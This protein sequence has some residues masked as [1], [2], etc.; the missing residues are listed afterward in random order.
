MV[1]LP[2][3]V[4]V[5]AVVVRVLWSGYSD[6]DTARQARDV[7]LEETAI[8]YYARA[9]RWYLPVVGPGHEAMDELMAL[10]KDIE[11]AGR[12]PVALRCAREARAAAMSTRWL[13]TPHQ[14]AL[15]EANKGIARLVSREKG[16][17]GLPVLPVDRHMELL[18]RDLTP[19][20]WLSALAVILFLAWVGVT[21]LG[22]WRSIS[23]QGR[24]DWKRFGA[25]FAASA[26]LLA[27]WLLVLRLA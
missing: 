22:A 10:C 12:D 1:L 19:D 25:Y 21:A 13:I 23:R 3:A 8:D 11:A 24:V 6:I 9:A 18:N 27:L 2:L 17:D 15:D 5:A 4:V 26:V 20:P 14:D 7:G 16:P